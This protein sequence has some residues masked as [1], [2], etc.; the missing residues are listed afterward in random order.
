MPQNQ[1]KYKQK[2]P[3]TFT[4]KKGIQRQVFPTSELGITTRIF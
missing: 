4:G 3:Q 2:P 1:L